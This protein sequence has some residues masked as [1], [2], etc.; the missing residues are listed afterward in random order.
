[1]QDYRAIR[2]KALT[3]FFAI[4]L[5]DQASK[6]WANSSLAGAPPQKHLGILTLTYAQN[7]GA[8]GSLGANWPTTIRTFALIVIPA[9]V[10]I[11]LAVHIFRQQELIKW[12][13]YG[14]AFLVSGGLGNLIDRVRFR[15]VIDFLYLGYGPIGTNI[16]NI[17]DMAVLVGAGLLIFGSWNN[18]K[19]KSSD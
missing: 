14:C 8:W 18:K 6:H 2:K 7:S 1:M 11:A 13:A 3:I 16:F 12:E 15:Y 5:L 10:L 9:I 4:L 17:A 19:E